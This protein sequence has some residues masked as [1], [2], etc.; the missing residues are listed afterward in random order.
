[1]TSAAA[2]AFAPNKIQLDAYLLYKNLITTQS[3]SA[4]SPP[5][6]EFLTEGHAVTYNWEHDTDKRSCNHAFT[7]HL[8]CWLYA[9][10]MIKLN[11]KTQEKQKTIYSTL[12]KADSQIYG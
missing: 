2:T 4:N 5:R 1:M 12:Y 8:L 11:H 3:N 10:G 9:L 7:S 6:N